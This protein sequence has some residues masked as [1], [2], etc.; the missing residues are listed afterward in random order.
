[1]KNEEGFLQINKLTGIPPTPSPI[2]KKSKTPGEQVSA[3]RPQ[4]YRPLPRAYVFSMLPQTPRA[5]GGE[6]R[7]VLW[8][9]K[10]IGEVMSGHEVAQ[11]C[12]MNGKGDQAGVLDSHHYLGI[13]RREKV[14]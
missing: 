6:H 14:L 12:R 3:L 4:G 2:W 5:Q 9:P 11:N 7:F 10:V 8:P 1:M 13:W